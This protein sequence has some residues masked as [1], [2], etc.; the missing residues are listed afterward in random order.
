MKT[1]LRYGTVHVLV[2]LCLI[3]L[4]SF[5]H[6][7]VF[8]RFDQ[9]SSMEIEGRVTEVYWR[10]PHVYVFVEVTDQNDERVIWELETNTASRLLRSGIQSDSIKVGDHVRAAGWP[11]VTAAKEIFAT[12][13]LLPSGEE[14]ILTSRAE[15]IWK[16]EAT[17]DRSFQFHTEGDSSRPDLGIFRTWNHTDVIPM[18]FP[19]AFDT[20]YD[21]NDY[22]MTDVARATLAA[23]D[24]ATDN[25][26]L[27]CTPKGMPTIM[28]Q[29][30]PMEFVQQDEN[31]FLRI[32]EYD[33]VRMIHMDDDRSLEEQ[34]LS[35]L[36]Y[37]VG[38]WDGDTLVVTTT[39]LNWPFFDQTGIPQSEDAE[40]VERFDPT[41]DGSRLDYELTVTDPLNFTEP[42]I[43]E[44]YWLYLLDEKVLPFDCSVR[45]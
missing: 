33:L 11:P 36:G 43:S 41:E 14:L 45:G 21:V 16:N 37:S 18:L 31:V 3:P 2:G 26:T 25:P 7:S 40:L 20:D 13:L 38:T 22:P 24:P 8:G 15:P 19:A 42:V 39:R 23:Y 6:H 17:G 35:P 1:F 34:P 29:P 5:S 12:N 9:D 27:N 10:N 4:T 28:E 30:Y 32:E 44:K